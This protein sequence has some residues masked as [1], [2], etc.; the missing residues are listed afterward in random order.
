MRYVFGV[1]RLLRVKIFVEFEVDWFMFDN[2]VGVGVWNKLFKVLK[3]Y[4]RKVVLF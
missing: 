1:M 3:E 4:I 2:K